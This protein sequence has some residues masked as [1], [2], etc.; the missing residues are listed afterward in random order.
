MPPPSTDN[1]ILLVLPSWVGDAVMATPALVRIRESFP[2][3]F[4]GAMARPGIDRLIDGLATPSGQSVIDEFHVVRPS[5]VMGPK[6]AASKLRPRCYARALLFT[7]SFSTALAVRVAGIH[8]RI[9]YDRDGRGFLLTRR[10]KPPRAESGGWAVVPA[11]SYY[12]HA[13]NALIDPR[14]PLQLTAPPLD[15]PRRVRIDLPGGLPVDASMTLPITNADRAEADAVRASAHIAG[16]TAI[17]NPGGNNPAKRWPANRFAALAD[18]LAD[19]HNLTV[20]INGSP[21]EA[22]LCR[23]I[24]DGAR[25]QPV[26]LPD[27]PHSLGSLKAL[28]ADARLMVTND[29]GPR[30]IAA[31]VGTPLVSLFGPTDPRWTTIPVPGSLE[32]ILIADETLPPGEISNDHPERCAIENIPFEAVMSAADG[33]LMDSD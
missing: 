32:V 7:G 16:P 5:G 28:A 12:W 25:T 29:T 13:A 30:H 24:S 2:G 8:E 3:A 11:V 17:L 20:L 9:G 14:L 19:Q 22:D 18:H 26:V 4:I 1:R 33:M 27:H 31:A 10:L 15:E 6:H 23:A 21:A